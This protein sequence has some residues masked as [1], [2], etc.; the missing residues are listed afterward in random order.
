VIEVCDGVTGAVPRL[1][2]KLNAITAFHTR[3]RFCWPI[4]CQDQQKDAIAVFV[5]SIIS[6]LVL[7]LGRWVWTYL[8]SA[9]RCK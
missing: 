8:S 7:L 2:D 4:I 5:H 1:V 3:I 9:A 6:S